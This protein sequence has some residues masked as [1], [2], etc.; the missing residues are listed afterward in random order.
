MLSI[1]LMVW[2]CTAGGGTTETVDTGSGGLIL[3]GLQVEAIP[4]SPLAAWL[5][6]ET[7]LPS[8]SHVEFSAPGTQ[9]LRTGHDGVTTHHEVLVYGMRAG[10]TYELTAI[11]ETLD[12]GRVTSTPAAF[13]P[14]PLPDHVPS[15]EVLVHE[16]DLAREG[17]TLFDN[18][19]YSTS[20]PNT[21]VIVDMEGHP[22][23]VHAFESGD[24]IGAM[25]VRLT[26]AGTV[27]MGA[28]VPSGQRPREVDFAGRILWEGPE[29]PGF[30]S[31][32]FM[33][34]TMEILDDDTVLTLVKKFVDG[35]R[36]DRIVIMDRNGVERWQWDFFENLEP[37][38]EEEWTHSNSVT[39]RGD[40]LYLSERVANQV[41]KIA[42][43]TGE[44]QWRLGPEGDFVLPDP[45]EAQHAPDLLGDDHFLIYDNG[46]ERGSTRVL[47]VVVDAEAG[48][49][50]TVWSWPPEGEH[51]WY[52]GY[53]GD[54]DRLDNGN[55]LIAAGAS[56]ENTMTEVTADGTVAWQAEWPRD[57][58][59]VVG[60]YRAERIDLPGVAV[61]EE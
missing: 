51:H 57:G 41:I 37:S 60:F 6:W 38:W 39:L 19:R 16:P 28:S 3:S 27:L 45:F 21:A 17:Y 22:V 20:A 52:T 43:S 32:D 12:G 54:A 42:M 7:N 26:D 47:E 24:D 9:R 53:W 55:T 4:E 11:S 29:Q 30:T 1:G 56:Y 35:T 8:D 10:V 34:H 25:D 58:D 40:D 23:W 13:T 14:G 48:T 33:H 61:V 46:T 15:P 31:D 36:G 5:R 59:L 2:G 50:E 44:I 49:A 18:Y